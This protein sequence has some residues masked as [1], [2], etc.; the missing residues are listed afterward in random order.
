VRAPPCR[1]VSSW[2]R[3]IRAM[4][5]RSSGGGATTLGAHGSKPSMI[6]SE[7]RGRRIPP[8]LVRRRAQSGRHARGKV[9]WGLDSLLV[10]P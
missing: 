7:P 9:E 4:W 8:S 1:P 2:R 3:I 5:S 6:A 10:V